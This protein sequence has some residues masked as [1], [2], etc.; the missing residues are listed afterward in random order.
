LSGDGPGPTPARRFC[1]L[2][3]GRTGS[4]SLLDALAAHDDILVPAKLVDSADNELV[5][6]ECVSRYMRELSRMVGARIDAPEALIEAFFRLGEGHAYVGF[7]SMPNRHRD[8]AAFVGR[9]DIRFIILTRADVAATVASFAVALE[10]TTWRRRGG[11]QERW[12]F[13][14]RHRPQ[15]L[16]LLDYVLQSGRLLADVPHAVRL[17]YEELC[18]PS[19]SCPPLD[20]F[21]RRTVRLGEPKPPLRAADYVTNHEEFE[22]FI[23]QAVWRQ[24]ATIA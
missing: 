18:E 10:R 16:D 9:S 24:R 5:H 20:L 12:T 14:P 22:S 23:A 4:T 17:S 8:L 13:E 2:T 6:P 19:F 11:P 7:K 15:V 3:T 1:L 21:F